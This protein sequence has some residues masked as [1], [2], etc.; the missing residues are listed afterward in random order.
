MD[1]IPSK[2][3]IYFGENSMELGDMMKKNIG[4]ILFFVVVAVV[5]VL[6]LNKEF[7][8]TS[9]LQ[10]R[11]EQAAVSSNSSVESNDTSSASSGPP[12]LRTDDPTYQWISFESDQSLPKPVDRT[13]SVSIYGLNVTVTGVSISKD[14]Q[15]MSPQK[16]RD[17]AD[18]DENGTITS[19]DSYVILDLTIT[20]ERFYNPE[21]SVGQFEILLYKDDAEI[22]DLS[23][24]ML[25][26]TDG[27]PGSKSFYFYPLALG[28]TVEIRAGYVVPDEKIEQAEEFFLRVDTNKRRIE[29]D[30]KD[31]PKYV[32][33]SEQTDFID[34]TEL[35]EAAKKEAGK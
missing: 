20:N 5:G 7:H 15:G 19:D 24:N 25:L 16:W 1:M 21:V 35:V 28:E 17:I 29:Y 3:E 9:Y 22:G 14:P 23:D 27:V 32:R 34:M 6:A 18:L 26:I 13:K 30:D 4:I 33:W 31:N 11:E 2:Q 10:P 8:L 12:S